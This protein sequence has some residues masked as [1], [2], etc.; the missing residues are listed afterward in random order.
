MKTIVYSSSNR[1]D[2]EGNP[3]KRN[4]S[5]YPYSYDEFVIWKKDYNPNST[6]LITLYSD[7]L[8]TQNREKFNKYCKEIWNNEGQYF[9]K[10]ERNT[11]D[12]ELFLKKY[13]DKNIKL[14]VI[15]EGCNKSNGYPVW[16]FICE[17]IEKE[18]CL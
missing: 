16:R 17:E 18:S 2:L 5:D 6:K 12:I 3:I 8:V 14:V 9:Y 13:L 11:E 4:K 7:R 10:E 15:L 1:F